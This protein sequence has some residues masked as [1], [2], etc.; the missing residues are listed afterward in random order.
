MF[1]KILFFGKKNDFLTKKL[2]N[3]LK[4]KTKKINVILIGEIKKTEHFL[5][6]LDV[7]DAYYDYI[8]CYRSYYI[9]KNSDIKKAKFACINFHPGSPSYRGVGC[10][11]YAIYERAKFYGVTAHIINSKIDN[12]P[13]LDV[14][15]FKIKKNESL[16]SLL[17]RTHQKLYTQSKKIINLLYKDNSFLEKLKFK[18]RKTRW[19]NKILSKAD[20]DNFYE[21]KLNISREKFN[22]KI[23]ATR[24][25][26][27]R[28]YI[29]LYG[30]KFSLDI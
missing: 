13:I 19:S 6:Y 29:N 16:P 10:S 27:F 28:P 7:P 21:I 26:S 1:K 17:F 15:F 2:I 3:F 30:K 9:L 23:L 14:N 24:Y 5:K 20:L 11:N 4:K 12:G 18:W 8:F 22:R 25:R